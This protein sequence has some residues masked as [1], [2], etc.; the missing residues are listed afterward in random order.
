MYRNYM[1]YKNLAVCS[2]QMLANYMKYDPKNNHKI[3]AKIK[4]IV[5]KLVKN[6]HITKICDLTY[7]EISDKN[8]IST[9]DFMFYVEIPIPLE[10][11]YF[12]VFDKGI[13]D[14]FEYL[15]DKKLNKFNLVRYY[16][17]C[18]RVSNNEA[19][20]GYLTQ[21]KLKKLVSDSRTIQK[22]N[23]ILQDELRLILYNN[24]YL[25]PD[26]HYCTTYIGKWDDEKNFNYQLKAEVEGKGLIYT[27]KT[28]SN[29]RRSIQQKINNIVISEEEIRDA[30]IKELQKLLG[31][32][33]E[34]EFKEI[35][36]QDNRSITE[37]KGKGLKNKKL[38]P[39]PVIS[40]DEQEELEIFDSWFD[41]DNE[42]EYEMTEADVE[43]MHEIE[44]LNRAQIPD[45]V[46]RMI[47]GMEDDEEEYY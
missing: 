39:L 11:L 21:G 7:K 10:N 15:Q 26:K 5:G 46:L 8:P 35:P 24:N 30:R 47:D 37:V 9:K 34:L 28:K 20:F 23:K 27:D 3:N 16:I 43:A 22:Y 40:E 36:K 12:K 33:K 13:D 44:A 4:E 19:N 18:S 32:K 25:T 2:I 45:D 1:Q 17:A 31:E 29:E 14:I 41:E 42:R 38:L 6:K